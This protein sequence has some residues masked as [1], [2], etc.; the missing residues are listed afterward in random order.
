VAFVA[1][2]VSVELAPAAI[3]AG[4]AVML[5]AG[6]PVPAWTEPQP[7]SSRNSEHEIAAMSDENVEPSG[8]RARTFMV[9]V[10]PYLQGERRGQ[11]SNPKKTD[12]GRENYR[13]RC[14]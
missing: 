2:T 10:L 4:V 12:A 5:T 14:A 7:A 3:D 13:G 8:R 9:L 6:V 1:V 11:S